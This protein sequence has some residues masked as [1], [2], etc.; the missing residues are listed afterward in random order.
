LAS[1]GDDFDIA[2]GGTCGVPTVPGCDCGAKTFEWEN[3]AQMVEYC[4]GDDSGENFIATTIG[5]NTYYACC[6]EP[7]DC[8]DESG[9][10]RIGHEEVFDL[11]INGIDDDC[12]GLIDG[13]DLQ[14]T[15]LLSGQ[16]YDEKGPVPGATVKGSPPGK[17]ASYEKTSS[18]TGPDGYYGIPDAL[19]GTYNFI[20]RKEG[21]DDDIKS[22]TIEWDA[23]LQVDFFLR[24][25]S[26]HEDCT[27]YYGNCNPDCNGTIFNSTSNCTMVHPL[28]A[29]RPRG[30]VAREIKGNQVYEYTCCEGPVVNYSVMDTGVTG[31]IEDLYDYVL[32]VKL[33]GRYVK[34]H[35][36]TWPSG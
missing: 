27:D 1:P 30:F 2:S 29:Y 13:E 6:D 14:C 5:A 4:C 17:G 18:P 31:N 16:V 10:C 26:C 32:S 20:A 33:G 23:S 21:Y 25:G 15:G 7:T 28:C 12:D 36:L 35:I 9:E 24:N 34:M 19:V 3:P 22:L 11:C 8:V